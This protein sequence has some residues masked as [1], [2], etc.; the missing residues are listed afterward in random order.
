MKKLF[1]V[2][3]ILLALSVLFLAATLL[4]RQTIKEPELEYE[5][6]GFSSNS[7]DS[8]VL[9]D[10]HNKNSDDL[11]NFALH[12]WNS[13][14]GYVWGTF[15][16]VLDEVTVADRLS[17]Y[18]GI[19]EPK[20][21]FIRDNWLGKRC[22]DCSGLIKAYLWYEPG[23]GINYGAGGYPDYDADS[24]FRN[25]QESGPID[26]IPELPGIAVWCEGH[27]GIYIGDGLIVEAM[28]TDYG[29]VKTRLE[30]YI[31]SRW[32]H[33]LKLEGVSYP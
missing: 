25:A 7:F 23:A 9:R 16:C 6:S 30:G 2:L 19:M 18:P 24:L 31:G 29:V 5:R 3:W 13:G 8:L 21:D 20:L 27:I 4:Y 26:T 1:R 17:L 14:W 33:W 11:A 22:A 32:T 12:A 10:P 28:G 15:G